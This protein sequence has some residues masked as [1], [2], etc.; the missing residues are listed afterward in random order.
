MTAATE[1]S[2]TQRCLGGS[3]LLFYFQMSFQEN[4]DSF[5]SGSEIKSNFNRNSGMHTLPIRC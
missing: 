2:R 5:L 3:F 1:M 4:L